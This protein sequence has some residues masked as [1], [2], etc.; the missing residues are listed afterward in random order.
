MKS[1]LIVRQGNDMKLDRKRKNRIEYT[2]PYIIESIIIAI[3]SS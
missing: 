1:L 3:A 2:G